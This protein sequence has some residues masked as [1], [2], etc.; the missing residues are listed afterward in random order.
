MSGYGSPSLA[1]ME[2]SARHYRARPRFRI[3]RILGEPFALSTITIAIVRLDFFR[4]LL[5]S[6]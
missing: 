5:D 6:S 4:G 2:A 3:D 1:K